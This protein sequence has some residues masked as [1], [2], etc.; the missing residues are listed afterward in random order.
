MLDFINIS[1]RSFS[2]NPVKP[3]FS[4]DPSNMTN[5][6]SMVNPVGVGVNPYVPT[7]ND[8]SLLK[9]THHKQVEEYARLYGMAISYQPKKYDYNT[10]NFLYGEDTT[11]GFYPVRKLKAIINQESYTSFLSKFGIMSDMDMVIYLPIKAF[12]SVWGEDLFPLA[13][14]LFR[15][16]DSACSRPRGQKAMVLEVTDAQDH[17]DPVDFMGGHYTWKLTCKRFDYSYEPNVFDEIGKKG[18]LGDSGQY[19]LSG[20]FTDVG[21]PQK[22]DDHA[23]VDF[24]NRESGIF[25]NYL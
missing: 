9:Q 25:G 7:C 22:S 2:F 17:I 10:H 18:G 1:V 12:V 13:G 20:N 11:S 3:T 15:I 14:D 19:G 8:Q 23:K 16:D 21:Y 24:E 6:T 4:L 5:K